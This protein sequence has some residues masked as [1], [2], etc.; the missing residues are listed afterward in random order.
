MNGITFKTMNM[1]KISVKIIGVLTLLS[2]FTAQCEDKF[3]DLN[4]NPNEITNPDI[5]QLL[6]NGLYNMCGDEYLQWF[7]NNSV[8]FWRF[9]QI[10]VSRSGTEQDF[11]NFGAMG[12]IPLYDVM[13]DMKEIRNR[14]EAMEEEDKAKY[15]H[16]RAITYI[17]QVYLGLKATDWQGSLPYSEA[18]E[19][20]YSGN[21]TPKYDTQEELFTTWLQ[22]LDDAISILVQDIDNQ[23]SPENQDFIYGGDNVA[24]ARLANSLRLRIAARM[25]HADNTAMR[26]VLNEIVSTKDNEG[27]L[28]LITDFDQQ[29]IWAPG[30]EE[31]GPGGT[32]SLWIENYGPSQNFSKFMI[33]NQDPRLGIFFVKNDLNDDAIDSLSIVPG[34]TLPYYANKPVVDPWDRLIGAPVAPDSSSI[35]DYFGATL[36]DKTGDTYNR[37]P[38]VDYNLFKP[39]QNDREGE[40]WNVFLGAPEVCFYLAE[41]IEKGYIAGQGT[42]QEWYET[43]IR[44]SCK[45]YDHKAD[46]AQVP[47]YTAQIKGDLDRKITTEQIDELLLQP[48]VQYV[49][50]DPGN[51][52]KIILQ[53]LI[54][55]FDNPYEG[56]A[57]SRRTGYPKRTST[58]WS[59]QPYTVNG[60]ELSL[61]RRFPWTTPSD[62]TNKANWQSALSAQGF[63]PDV[64]SFDVLNTQRVWW[65]ENCPDYGDGE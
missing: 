43:G 40:Y 4:Q 21:M 30:G 33:G 7:Y 39:K 25:E 17:P 16:L 37:L 44:I 62:A 64:T 11:N 38:Y 54:N 55:L 26:E 36:S 18:V 41:F 50:G 15:Q 56:V 59:W 53:Q 42:A 19:A 9:E 65:D 61:A 5:T 48:S 46:Q 3:S 6:T 60:T 35:A 31:L 20:R 57:V 24:W 28:L 47:D 51:L 63:T 34:V 27:N 13:I 45:N 52:E 8:Y 22:E 12:G 49:V 1:K 32:N 2:L 10:T 23:Y 14:I 58:L 29:A